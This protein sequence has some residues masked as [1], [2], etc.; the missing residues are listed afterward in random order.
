[1]WFSDRK[2][3]ES[4]ATL[5]GAQESH[6]RFFDTNFVISNYSGSCLLSPEGGGIKLPSG[7]VVSNQSPN[8]ARRF[9]QPVSTT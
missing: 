5:R 2:V 9:Y 6:S 1:M 8:L 3:E 4:G 7:S